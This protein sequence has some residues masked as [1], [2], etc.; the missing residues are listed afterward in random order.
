MAAITVG[1]IIVQGITEATMEGVTMGAY[2]IRGITAGIAVDI[3]ADII[4][5]TIVDTAITRI[6][7]N[8]VISQPWYCN[9]IPV[10]WREQGFFVVIQMIWN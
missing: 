9:T 6:A 1:D 8:V 5:D 3:I 10:L 4:V 7:V 2:I